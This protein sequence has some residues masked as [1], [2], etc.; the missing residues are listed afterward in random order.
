MS[1][2][3]SVSDKIRSLRDFWSE[4]QNR[5]DRQALMAKRRFKV[6]SSL[7]ELGEHEEIVRQADRFKQSD[8]LE[9]CERLFRE[10]HAAGHLLP[11]CLPVHQAMKYRLF[12]EAPE[13]PDKQ[14]AYLA[15]FHSA[16]DRAPSPFTAALLAEALAECASASRGSDWVG[17]TSEE[18]WAAQA[19]HAYKARSILDACPDSESTCPFWQRANY[20]VVIEDA[21]EREEVDEAF[22]RAWAV[23]RDN[24]TLC[25]DYGI[26]MLPRWHGDGPEDL[27]VFAR[28]AIAKT[29]GRFGRG[30]YAFI[31]GAQAEI[32]SHEVTDTLCDRD[33]LNRAFDDLTE[34]FPD[35]QSLLNRQIVTFDWIEDYDTIYRVQKRLTTINPDI[36]YWYLG[37][38]KSNVD[39][40]LDTL[41][42]AREAAVE[43]RLDRDM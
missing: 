25:A 23:D 34:R 7:D 21:P 32:G 9:K 39:D 31:Y 16:F 30:A 26:M 15:P 17:E 11:G 14:R 42:F 28:R 4:R 27:E 36:W 8:Q 18:Q 38:E 19:A 35:S 29:E 43:K 33:L 3:Q 22:E 5:K 20:R 13:K 1:V 2:V 6:A 24:L 37:D 12:G 40:A 10:T 41:L